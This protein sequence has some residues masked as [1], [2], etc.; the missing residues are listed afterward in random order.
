MLT[1]LT[2]AESRRAQG[3]APAEDV[4]SSWPSKGLEPAPSFHPPTLIPRQASIVP[5]SFHLQKL[6]LQLRETLL[7]K[8]DAITKEQIPIPE[9]AASVFSRSNGELEPL[10]ILD[11]KNV[12]EAPAA[13]EPSVAQCGG[14]KPEEDSTG[15][16]L[17]LSQH[18]GVG[19]LGSAVTKGENAHPGEPVVKPRLRLDHIRED[20]HPEEPVVKPLLR[21]DH[22]REDAHPEE[23]AVKALLRLDHIREDAHP[24]ESVV[25]PLL[26]L[27][28][29]REVSTAS[30]T[31]AFDPR[32]PEDDAPSYLL[33]SD[34]SETK[35]TKAQRKRMRDNARKRA[36]RQQSKIAR[37]PS[38]ETSNSED[39][40]VAQ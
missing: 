9:S 5:Q 37:P 39:N 32:E 24:E 29:I 28:H 20:A 23:P 15:V 21:L 35:L 40:L 16:I 1:L 27:D 31:S 36:Q 33:D 26:R 25:K 17:Q 6:Q 12:E 14:V 18:S 4:A 10:N 38:R 19:S 8:D 30:A 22:I 2:Q 3:I 34:V 13:I 11:A 7:G